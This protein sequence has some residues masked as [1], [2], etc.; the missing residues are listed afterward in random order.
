[1]TITH[2]FHVTMNNNCNYII[3]WK[4]IDILIFLILLEI[5]GDF[6]IETY[7]YYI[8]IIHIHTTPTCLHLSFLSSPWAV[9]F[10]FVK[11]FVHVMSFQFQ[12]NFFP[13]ITQRWWYC[14]RRLF[15]SEKGCHSLKDDYPWLEP[16]PRWSKLFA[17]K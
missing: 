1:M 16:N 17:F 15:K 2:F 3:Y 9:T 11:S 12:W 8:Y 7:L 4:H 5:A 13:Y 6:H 10:D 14:R